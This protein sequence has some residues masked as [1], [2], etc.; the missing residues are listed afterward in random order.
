MHNFSSSKIEL[1][2][3][4]LLGREG[5]GDDM[6]VKTEICKKHHH[7]SSLAKRNITELKGKC[8]AIPLATIEAGKWLDKKQLCGFM[9]K[10]NLNTNQCA[11][12]VVETNNIL[13][14]ISK[15]VAS[16]SRDLIIPLLPVQSHI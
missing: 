5:T 3:F 4:F 7:S 2:L 14:C 10:N 8:R 13:G 16:K 1:I 15:T 12:T 9:V 11:H 6:L